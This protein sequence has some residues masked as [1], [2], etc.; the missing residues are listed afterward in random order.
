MMDAYCFVALTV[1]FFV[2]EI[3]GV[4]PGGRYRLPN[5]NT[6]ERNVRESTS[7]CLQV[8][9]QLPSKINLD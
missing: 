8:K 2:Q 4:D 7:I 1:Y 3:S 9:F 5:K 6:G